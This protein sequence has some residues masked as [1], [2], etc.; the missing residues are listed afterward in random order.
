MYKR[1]EQDRAP[2]QITAIETGALRQ[3]DRDMLQGGISVGSREQLLLLLEDL[4]S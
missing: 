4:G 3:T 2:L 1:Q